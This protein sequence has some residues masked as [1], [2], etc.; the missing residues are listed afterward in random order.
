MSDR[1]PIFP[2]MG[3][4]CYSCKRSYSHIFHRCP[5]CMTPTKEPTP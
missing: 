5:H 3:W 4:T 1:R 2:H